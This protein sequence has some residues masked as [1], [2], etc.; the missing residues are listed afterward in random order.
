ML[1]IRRTATTPSIVARGQAFQGLE[2][3]HPQFDEKIALRKK[4]L[5]SAKFTPGSMNR[6]QFID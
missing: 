6:D 4:R 3:R 2:S 5:Q 1:T